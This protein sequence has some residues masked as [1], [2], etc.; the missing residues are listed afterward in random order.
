MSI[1]SYILHRCQ[2]KTKKIKALCSEEHNALFLMKFHYQVRSRIAK[3]CLSTAAIPF[4]R[5][6]FLVAE[7]FVVQ[8]A[9]V[10]M[11]PEIRLGS[12]EPVIRSKVLPISK[13][14]PDLITS[15]S[16]IA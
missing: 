4:S 12:M 6:F 7:S 13:V 15:K 2:V 3:I 10:E 5:T 11:V 16:S 1:V 14:M 9:F 8:V